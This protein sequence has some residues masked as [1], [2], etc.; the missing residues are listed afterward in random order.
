MMLLRRQESL[1]D[2]PAALLTSTACMTM[3][4]PDR[5]LDVMMASRAIQDQQLEIS[6]VTTCYQEL[7]PEIFFSYQRPILPFRNRN[8]KI[9]ATWQHT[10]RIRNMEISATWQR[11]IRIRNRNWIIGSNWT[12]CDNLVFFWIGSD[13]GLLVTWGIL[14]HFWNLTWGRILLLELDVG[15]CALLKE[16]VATC[17]QINNCVLDNKPSSYCQP[18]T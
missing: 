4:H 14:H 8:R 3:C 13:M 10:I 12:C 7:Q 5:L 18:S 9:S 17:H 1:A 2:K 11:A 16:R 15:Q 6:I